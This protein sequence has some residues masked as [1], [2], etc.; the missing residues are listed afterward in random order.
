MTMIYTFSVTLFLSAFLLFLVQPMIGKMILPVFGG[1]PAVWNTCLVFFQ[2]LLLAGYVYAHLL[3][4]RTRLRHQVTIHAALMLLALVMLPIQLSN[5]L[6]MPVDATPAAWLLNALALSAG[7]PFFVVSASA[8]LFQKWLAATAHPVAKDPYPLYAVSNTGSLLGLLSYPLLIEPGLQITTQSRLWVLGYELLVLMTL[9][10]G[11]LAWRSSTTTTPEASR[12]ERAGSDRDETRNPRAITA[13][14]RCLWVLAAFIPSSLLLGVTA[15]IT[16][17]LAAVP[18]LWVIPLAAYLISFVLVFARRQLVPQR[19]IDQGLPYV[20]L[21]LA[22]VA[23]FQIE[24][25]SWLSIPIN[26]LLFFL[27][28]LL[29]HGRLAE[30]RPA[31]GHLTEFYL[32]ISVG[33]VMGGVF[34]TFVAPLVFDRVIEYPLALVLTALLRRS[35]DTNA[36]TPRARWLDVGLPAG[37]G[38]ASLGAVF[39]IPMQDAQS[40]EMILAL[41][42]LL[43]TVCFMA[44]HNPVRFGLS[45]G[46]FL[47]TIVFGAH[48]DAG[49]RVLHIERDFFGVKKVLEDPERQLH[50]LVHGDIKHG[51]QRMS[52]GGDREPLAYYHRSGPIGD[53]FSAFAGTALTWRVAIIGL[54]VGSMASYAEPGQHFTFYEVDPAIARIAGDPQYFTFLSKCRGTYDLVIGDGRLRL[55]RAPDAHYGMIIVDAFSSDAIPTHLLTREALRLYLAKLDPAGLLVL[56][57]SNSYLNF[58]ALLGTMAAAEGLAG[59]ARHHTIPAAQRA[60]GQFP[61]SYVVMARSRSDLGRLATHPQWQPVSSEPGGVVWTDDY[62]NLWSLLRWR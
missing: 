32:W 23:L 10:C 27:A 58:D 15:H 16:T 51:V 35:T 6:S 9:G 33:G 19:I 39:V 18:L 7:I 22:P 42:V 14:Q 24:G 47:F 54:G 53:V 57:T 31:T 48:A 1:T 43:A 30:S 50:F 62:S 45:F 17:N 61:S 3:T 26:V 37:L 44:K 28:A 60:G 56:H 2:M 41:G 12:H 4:T 21:L 55:A 40:R 25:L 38:L 52:S 29:C 11:L 5:E 13:R 36:E 20:L 34:N 8:P 59:V 46:V 49:Y